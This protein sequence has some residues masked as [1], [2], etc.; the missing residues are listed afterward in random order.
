ML[1]ALETNPEVVVVT[2]MLIATVTLCVIGVMIILHEML[3]LRGFTATAYGTVV[4]DSADAGSGVKLVKFKVKEV[5]FT[6]RLV[7]N[8]SKKCK[9]GDTLYI[10]YNPE[11]PNQVRFDNL[12]H[13][14]FVGSIYMA[15]ALVLLFACIIM[16]SHW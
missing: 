3:T 10:Y 13:A 16:T 14:L 12:R 6:T 8:L 15:I 7:S 5:E 2:V 4:E 11:Q 1:K 9:A